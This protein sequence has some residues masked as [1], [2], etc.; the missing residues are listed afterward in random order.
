MCGSRGATVCRAVQ[1]W[2]HRGRAVSARAGT[3]DPAGAAPDR[4]DGLHRRL[5]DG[6]HRWLGSHRRAAA[7]ARRFR[8][9]SRVRAVGA[10]RLCAGARIAHADRRSARRCLRT[11]AD[12]GSRMHR[13]R[14]RIRGVRPGAIGD[15]AHRC[16]RRAGDRCR[17]RHAGKPCT[18]RRRLSARGAQPGDRRVGC[19]LG[20]DHRGRADPGRVADGE[21]RLAAGVLDQ[22]TACAHRC[23]ASA[24]IRAR[25]SPR[26]TSVRHA[27]R[28]HS[29]NLARRAGV[30]AQ[31]DRTRRADGNARSGGA[32]DHGRDRRR[33]GRLCRSM[34]SGRAKAIAR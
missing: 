18:D 31:P 10:E 19:R 5:L 9:G 25:G 29:R 11:G 32:P 13:L 33:A 17:D 2:R 23:R 30:G 27:R 24:R 12:P 16:A 6:V 4:A 22:S 26:E 21:F 34:R 8:R 3:R 20:A 15:A 7:P 1:S 28:R 14:A